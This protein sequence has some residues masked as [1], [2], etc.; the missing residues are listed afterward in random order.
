MLGSETQIYSPATLQTFQDEQSKYKSCWLH[1]LLKKK[2]ELS[3]MF[4]TK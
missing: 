4:L 2:I 1:Y 3:S